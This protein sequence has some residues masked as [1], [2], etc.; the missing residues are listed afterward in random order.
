MGDQSELEEGEDKSDG[1]DKE[2]DVAYVEMLQAVKSLL[3]LPDPEFDDFQPPCAFRKRVSQ[4][5]IYHLSTQT[6]MWLRSGRIG[7][8][9]R[10]GKT[11][12]AILLVHL[13][14]QLSTYSFQR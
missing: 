9:K 5:D 4:K 6:K 7:I 14:I 10:H 2:P 13:C 3:E 1:V 8:L 11:A 12:E